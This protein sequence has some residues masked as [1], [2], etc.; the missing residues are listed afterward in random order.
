MSPRAPCLVVL[1]TLLG[2]GGCIEKTRLP[3]IG[4]DDSLPGDDDDV[5]WPDDDS[6]GD[7][8]TTPLLDCQVDYADI[9]ADPD[10][11]LAGLVSLTKDLQPAIDSGCDCH[12]VGNPAIEDLSPGRVWGAWVEQ[13]SRFD[14]GAVLAVP[15]S[16]EMSAVFWKV[17]DCYPVFP[18]VG[19]RMPPNAPALTLDEVALYY[20]W[21]LQGA[22]DN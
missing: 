4:D 5:V 18:Y 12:Q 14:H 20:N 6:Q 10:G 7:D 22:E 1:A 3:P 8:D 17:F 13:P 19:V 21:I 16:P 2:M 9:P 11:S 15:G